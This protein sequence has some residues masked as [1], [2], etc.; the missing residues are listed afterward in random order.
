MTHRPI[1]ILFTIPNFKT[2]GSQYVL[3]S[4]IKGLDTSQ[5][6]I[7]VAVENHPDSMPSIILKEQQIHLNYSGRTLKDATYLAKILKQ[8]HIDI[9]HSWDYKSEIVE[10]LACRLS[11][12]K[13]VFTKK[14]N[15]WSKKWHLKSVLA[16]Q[17]AYDNPEMAVRFF[18]PKYLKNKTSFIPHGVDINKFVPVIKPKGQ[19]FNLCCIGNIVANKNQADILLAL[20]QL[21]DHIHL[22]L[23]GREDKDY[24][25]FLDSILKTKNLQE[26][27]HFNGFI[28]NE[29]IPA[30]LNQQD[31]FVLVSKQEGLPVSILEAL[32]CGIPVLSSDS[33][34]GAS[35]ILEDDNGGLLF[36]SVNQLIEH[37]NLLEKDSALY[38]SFSKKAVRNVRER[39]SLHK[40][41]CAY[42][43]LYLKVLIS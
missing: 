31:L 25:D 10:A 28:K 41:I 9:L 8:N 19:R 34:G 24:R 38:K 35:Y 37:I 42:K 13:Y 27:V 26:R 20:S 22:N 18:N 6:N 40:E 16:H 29:D 4:I 36:T 3:L 2:A 1:N 33:G 23:Y 15:S 39:F 11:R 30:V 17:I 7:Y 21:P 43:D 12:V 5:F 14:N 32:A